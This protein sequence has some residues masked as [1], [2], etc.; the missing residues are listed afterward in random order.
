SWRT[1]TTPL[2]TEHN[3]RAIFERLFGEGGNTAERA[4]RARKNLS[5]LDQV[6]KEMARLQSRLGPADRLRATEYFDAVRDVERR[7]QKAGQSAEPTTGT[8]GLEAPPVGIP[9]SFT[10]HISLMFDLVALAFRA[11]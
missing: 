4:D 3:P 10:D 11:D 6:T 1:P 8:P 9:E 2:P 7:L 5:I